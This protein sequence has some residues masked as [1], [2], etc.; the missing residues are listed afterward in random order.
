MGFIPGRQ[1]F[2]NIHRS[3]SVIHHI[4]KLKKTKTYD[5]LDR[6][7]KTL[8]QDPTPISDKNTSDRWHRGNYINI[9]KAVYVE[10]T[11]DIILNGEKLRAGTRQGGVLS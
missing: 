9:I 4:H 1:G 7:T 3:I 10:P 6:R 11:A 8:W 5:P 2:F